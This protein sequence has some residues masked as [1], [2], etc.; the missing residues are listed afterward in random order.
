MIKKLL[1]R[2]AFLLSAAVL[3]LFA[4]TVDAQNAVKDTNPI[5]DIMFQSFGWDEFRLARH[6]TG[7]YNFYLSQTDY[8]SEA[9][10]DM[11]W[12]PP[13]SQSTGGVGYIPTQLFNFAQTAWGKEAELKAMLTKMNAV[14]MYPIADIVVNHRGGTRGWMDFTNP[15]WSCKTVVS[16]D[17]ATGNAAATPQPCGNQDTGDGFDGGR[18]LDHTQQETRDGVKEFLSRLK[19]LGFK[20]WRWDVAKGFAAQYF[21]EYNADSKP[22]YSVGEFWDGDSGKLK[23]WVDGTNKN[24]GIFD[25][26]NYYVLSN[27]LKFNSYGS[28]NAGGRMPGISGFIGYD[29]KSVTFVDNHDTFS[30]S[31]AILGDNI[32]KGYAY[33]LTHPA[34]PC[35]WA[36]HYYGGSYTKDG[37]TRVYTDNQAPINRLMAVRKQ[38]GINA[39][40]SVNIVQSGGTYAAYVSPTFGSQ[41]TVAVKIGPGNWSPEGSGWIMNASGTDYAV[42]S[43]KQISTPKAPDEAEVSIGL[44]GIGVTGTDAGWSSDV[45]MTS[46]DNENYIIASQTFVGGKVKFRANAAWTLNWGGTT[47]PNGTGVLDGA[48]EITVPAGTYKVEFNRKTAAYKFTL[49]GAPCVC[50]AVDAPVCANGKTYANACEAECAGQTVYTTGKCQIDP[51]WPKIGMVGSAVNDDTTWGTDVFM[52]T[53]DG[54]NYTLTYTF[55]IGETKFRQDSAWVNDWGSAAFPSGTGTK[56]AGNIPVPEAITYDVTFNRTTGVYFFEPNLSRSDFSKNEDA[57]NIQIYPN[58][59]QS[60]WNISAEEE[61]TSVSVLNSFGSTVATGKLDGNKAIVSGAGLSTGLYFAVVKTTNS[62]KTIKLI[63]R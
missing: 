49:I 41:P 29:D 7:F 55:K 21:G 22:Y 54:V 63:K 6:Q 50:A 11:I 13:P 38:N 28:L 40:S 52:Q 62:V 25:F 17:E 26:A 45:V 43:K 46:T 61:I 4:S 42:W 36:A 23:N 60:D 14:G 34:I 33:I 5:N 31:E 56:T 59:S 44:V 30:L 18:D 37:V 2:K 51:T 58:P 20:G 3:G 24:S 35:V 57:A 1:F 19:G 39:Y 48:I 10:V 27:A 9:G 12:M 8:L 16:N 47:F 15:T 32:M 53:T